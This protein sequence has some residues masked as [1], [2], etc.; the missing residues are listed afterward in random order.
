[1]ISLPDVNVLLALVWSNHPHHHAAHRWFARQADAGWATCIFTQTGFLRLSLNPR[2]VEVTID[3]E[4]ALGLLR[5]LVAHRHHQYVGTA[6]SL[7]DPPFNE[8]AARIVGYRQMTDATLLHLARS[9]QMKL[10][11]LDQAAASRCPWDEHLETI[12]P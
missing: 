11:T 10:L 2:V 4:T 5:G 6:P 1:M 7:L 12:V 8:L 3:C 9:H